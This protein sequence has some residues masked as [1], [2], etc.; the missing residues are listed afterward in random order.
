MSARG[1]SPRA[2]FWPRA[3]AACER[4][5]SR[6]PV[7][8]RGLLGSRV[9]AAAA[10]FDYTYDKRLYD[11]LVHGRRARCASTC[12][13]G[14]TSRTA[15]RASSRTTTSRAPPRPSRRLITAPRPRSLS[16]PRVCASFTRGSARAA[17]AHPDAPRARPGRGAPT[18][19]SARST[20]GCFHPQ[21]RAFRDG[22]VAVSSPPPRLAWERQQRQGSSSSRGP[23]RETAVPRRGELR[24]TPASATSRCR[25]TISTGGLAARGRAGRRVSIATARI[26]P[27][28][29]L[30][31]HACVGLSRLRGDVTLTGWILYTLNSE[32]TI[33]AL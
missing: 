16:L 23:G 29:A 12:T 10:G 32:G 31:R 3:T 1:A 11:R 21:D 8:G 24:R 33:C 7:H 5:G 26:W 15:S 13:P 28:G 6:L 9:G 30:S 20:T 14:S 25:G 22:R 4:A 17:G 19:R 2:P 18:R 27:A